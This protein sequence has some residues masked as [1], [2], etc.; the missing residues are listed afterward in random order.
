MQERVLEL[1]RQ[2]HELTLDRE[3]RQAAAAERAEIGCSLLRLGSS[4]YRLRVF[5]RGKA[6]AENVDIDFHDGY[7]LV[8]EQEVTRKFPMRALEPGQ[9]VDL[10]AGV[11]SQTAAK[12]E[13]NLRWTNADGTEQQKST[14]VTL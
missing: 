6:T 4:K 7:E 8:G 1:E 3:M 11:H 12:H 5:N 9:S 13:V 2:V 14:E 10:I